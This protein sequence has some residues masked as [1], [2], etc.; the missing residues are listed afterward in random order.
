MK[1]LCLLFH[2]KE[3]WDLDDIVPWVCVHFKKSDSSRRVFCLW[4]FGFEFLGWRVL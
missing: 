1:I 3:Q 4:R 2:R